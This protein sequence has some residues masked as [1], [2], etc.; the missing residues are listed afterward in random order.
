MPAKR[1]LEAQVSFQLG[2]ISQ[3][4]ANLIAIRSTLTSFTDRCAS[5]ARSRDGRKR[6]FPK[7]DRVT[8]AGRL[9]HGDGLGGGFVPQRLTEKICRPYWRKLSEDGYSVIF[10]INSVTRCMRH[11]PM[12]S[13]RPRF[14]RIPGRAWWPPRFERNCRPY[15]SILGLPVGRQQAFPCARTIPWRRHDCPV[16]K[17]PSASNWFFFAAG[18][19]VSPRRRNIFPPATG[20]AV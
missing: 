4:D 16:P 11:G 8:K 2:D 10:T 15:R 19:P 3:A 17:E 14:R 18:H 6:Y 5:H 12:Q 20:K 13:S 1:N 7:W 9:G